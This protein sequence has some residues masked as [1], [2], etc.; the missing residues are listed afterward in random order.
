[1][2]N[3]KNEVADSMDGEV[4]KQG[5]PL[6]KIIGTVVRL[7][8]VEDQDPADATVDPEAAQEEAMFE[9]LQETDQVDDGTMSHSTP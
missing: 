4:Y 3:L 5:T 6:L 2:K 9:W 8:L 1:L 7:K